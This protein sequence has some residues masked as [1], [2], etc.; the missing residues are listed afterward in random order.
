MSRQWR[1]TLLGELRAE[2]GARV[3]TRFCTQKTG[4]LLAY[5]AYFLDR[6]HPRDTLIDL[7]WPQAELQ[8]GRNSLSVALSSLRHQLEPPGVPAG[9][10]ILADRASVRL[11]PE[12]VTTD[13][14]DFDTALA[15]AERAD[16]GME[17]VQHLTRAVELYRAELLTG[18]Y[19][20]WVLQERGWQAERYFSAVSQLLARLEEVGEL[21]QALEVARQGV[22]IDPLREEL[23]RELI[24]LLGAAGQ[25]EAGLR[26]YRELE[27]LL[28]EELEAEPGAATRALARNLEQR[29]S[30][31]AAG[32]RQPVA[33]SRQPVDEEPAPTTA[34]VGS[35]EDSTGYRLPATGSLPSGTVTFLL[36]DVEGSTRRWE[37]TGDVF[38]TALASHHGLLRRAFRRHNG[39]E[40]KEMGEAFLVAFERAGDALAC[41]V[42]GQRAL[43]AHPWPEAVGPLQVRMALHTGDVHPQEGD[44]HSLLL[45][46]AQR[47]L[48]AGHG[49]QILCSEA[50]AGLLRRSLEPDLKL[51][52][53]GI[54]RLR[55]V[56]MP[57]RLFQVEYAGMTRTAFPPLK[58]EA[59]YA[60]HLPLPL[61][62][63]FGR[64]EEIEQLEKM[65]LAPE[66]RL[67]TLMGPGGS[68]KT[69]LAL[70]VARRLVGEWHG[71]VWFVPLADLTDARRI[72]EAIRD[73]MRLVDST[74][75][76]PLE[77]V[78][79]ALS[80]QPS[81]LLLDNLE[82]LLG[83]P[84]DG[85]PCFG[86][87]PVRALLERVPSL[88]LLVTSRQ[89]LNLTG[90]RE[91]LVPSLPIPDAAQSPAELLQC[92]SVQLFV[93]RAQ[94]VRPDFQVTARNAAAVAALCQRLEGI[95]LAIELT[96][97]R[98]QILTPAQMLAHLSP[99]PLRSG[100]G[101]GPAASPG[102]RS[103]RFDF[104]VS[105]QRD[106]AARHRTLRAAMEW[107]YRL[108]SP[109]LQRFFAGLSVFRG[110]WTLAAA[111]EVCEA[112]LSLDYLAQLRECSLVLAEEG[113]EEIRFWMLETLREYARE[114][115]PAPELAAM[116]ERHAAYYLALAEQAAP[117]LEGSGQAD[118]LDRLEREH[119]NLRV[120][121]AWSVARERAEVGLRLAEALGRFWEI[122][123]HLNEARERLAQLLAIPGAE[124]RT[125]LRAGVLSRAGLLAYSQ[126]DGRTAQSLLEE[127]LAIRRELDNRS[128]VAVSL[129]NLG[130]VAEQQGDLAAARSLYEESLALRR[131]LGGRLGIAMSLNELGLLAEA[132]GDLEAARALL[133]ESLAIKRELGNRRTLIS[134][135][136]NLGSVMYRQGDHDTGH[137][138][139]EEA[140][141]IG[142]EL[143]DKPGIALCVH[144]LGRFAWDRGEYA[145]ARS[146]YAESLSIE[147]EL[148][149]KRGIAE[150]LEALGKVVGALGQPERAARL[151]GAA[152]AVRDAIGAPHW[153]VD[154][155]EY[156]CCLAAVRST[157]DEAAFAAAWAA[158]RA[159][160]L[161]QAVADALE[162][163]GADPAN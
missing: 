19:E 72:G 74:D 92:E 32:R 29:A 101:A 131:K 148:G 147:R 127:S 21:S 24:R 146:H 120:A 11:S 97:S 60:S 41:A 13:V 117:E 137:G 53:L 118:W 16:S 155:A 61:T 83:P 113:G 77:Q 62:R 22:R 12:A 34:M 49:G 103:R 40:V 130:L 140:L 27:R 138:L 156:E 4:A 84:A 134:S 109:E 75:A 8:A 153:P 116:E 150:D 82:H 69:R 63:F 79:E 160:T 105:R 136:N 65:L 30:Q 26:Q 151:M 56:A 47:M 15:A 89:R 88:T 110:G 139:L 126:G 112:E 145:V 59:G 135:L 133:A 51:R 76:D 163:P 149:N 122:R 50:S 129:H 58:A 158:G 25:P 96:A 66:G 106:L 3:F 125:A 68:G 132:Q 108:L 33:G 90:E 42:A 107:S 39:Y 71:A 81:L 2:G 46:H 43:A 159:L 45:H 78:V 23:H 7:L 93:D 111:E 38:E 98:A 95:P 123:G 6:A 52:E 31:P 48:A 143:G 36:T 1:I 37:R 44:Y 114:Q 99:R 128:G 14:G 28:K 94:A 54:Y 142:R 87:A 20:E 141:A 35:A 73:A 91:F 18:S 86:T 80:R 115:C 57:E 100:E 55:D 5:L 157:L 154:R 85:A 121:L 17:R 162:E 104:L 10:V 119:D 70:E 102:D 9:S 144:N 161:E 124:A 67:I 64:E 152:A